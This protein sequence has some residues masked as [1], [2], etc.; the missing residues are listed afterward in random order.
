MP[1][2]EA[3]KGEAHMES[4][5]EN[6]GPTKP[7]PVWKWVIILLV[8]GLVSAASIDVW[9]AIKA[10]FQGVTGADWP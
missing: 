2:T 10:A 9:A 5:N 4:S 7:E 3:R 6:P 8:A 1:A